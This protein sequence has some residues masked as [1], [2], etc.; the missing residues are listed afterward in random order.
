MK[1]WKKAPPVQAIGVDGDVVKAPIAEFKESE[2][3]S[4]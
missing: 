3:P 2:A 4:K 1:Y